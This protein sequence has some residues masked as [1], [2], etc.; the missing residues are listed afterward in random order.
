MTITASG[1]GSMSG[2]A[3]L[4]SDTGIWSVVG[5]KLCVSF[6]SWTNNARHCGEVYRQGDTYVGFVKNGR[7]MLQFRKL[8]ESAQNQP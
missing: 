3:M 8:I 6:K 1:N 5:R 2:K 4:A 7:P